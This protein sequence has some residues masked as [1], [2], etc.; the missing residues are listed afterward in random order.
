MGVLRVNNAGLEA[1]VAHCEAVAARLVAATPAPIVARPAQATSGAV[2]A[3]YTTLGGAVS[4]LARRAQTNAVKAA[5]ASAEFVVTDGV[6][7]Q[8]IA[9]VG[10]SL[11]R[12]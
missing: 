11:D 8:N 10:V 7:A 2:D 1:L 4:I 3:A 9:T 12:V 6:G 5:V